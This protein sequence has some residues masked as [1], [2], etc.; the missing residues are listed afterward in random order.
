MG[1]TRV[2]F[3][4]Q[5]AI[6]GGRNAVSGQQDRIWGRRFGPEEAEASK[7]QTDLQ[8]LMENTFCV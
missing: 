3:K 7:P 4:P 8:S 2:S 5:N 1:L 6:E